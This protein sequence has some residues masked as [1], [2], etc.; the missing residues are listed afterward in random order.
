MTAFCAGILPKELS[1]PCRRAIV[2]VIHFMASVESG[3]A[4][5]SPGE[6]SDRSNDEI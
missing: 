1:P 6:K 4:Y 2:T 3:F 5:R